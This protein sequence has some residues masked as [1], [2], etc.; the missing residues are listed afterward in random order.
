MRIVQLS[1]YDLQGGAARA[2]LRLHRALRAAGE[3][4]TMFVRRTGGSEA[5]VTQ[6]QGPR[7]FVG[8]LE[9]FLRRQANSWMLRSYRTSRPA[10]LD[11]FSGIRGE[12]GASTIDQIP[13]ADVAN[14]HWIADAFLDL[15]ALFSRLP[16]RMPLVWTLHDMNALTGGCH[17]DDGCRR[18]EIG[19]GAC[20]QLGSRSLSDLSARLWRAKAHIYA[21]IDPTRLHLATPSRWLAEEARRS[22]LLNRFP[23]SVIANGL[24]TDIFRP[25][26]RRVAR[27]ALNLPEDARVVLFVAESAANRR[28]GYQQ[29]LQAL[30][31]LKDQP[32]L[33]LLT[34]GH[35]TGLAA[36]GLPCRQLGHISDEGL[37]ALA[38]SAADVFALPSLQ[39]NLPNTALEALACGTPIVGFDVG[40]IPDL[41]HP[42]ETGLLAP[43]ANVGAFASAISTLLNDDGQRESLS[44]GCRELALAEFDQRTQAARYLEL[45]QTLTQP[46]GERP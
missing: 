13:A 28:K 22:P 40:G 15:P 37:L 30:T 43:L 4:S 1:S 39:D 35:D 34:L 5:G 9:R 20:P 12:T 24:D 17:Y 32:G 29:L 2:A 7:S 41:V 6:A 11:V 45:Y 21:H 3:D 18:H 42:G 31:S 46:Q 19:C 44:R 10:G 27:S 16:S 25:I 23:V 14:L 8:R 26:D 36:H 38:Y 33:M